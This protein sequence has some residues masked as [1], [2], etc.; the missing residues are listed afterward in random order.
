VQ[1]NAELL[2]A[3]PVHVATDDATASTAVEYVQPAGQ[4]F[5]SLS[6]PVEDSK[7]VA[8]PQVCVLPTPASSVVA[9]PQDDAISAE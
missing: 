6:A 9:E 4:F 1:S 5:S 2:V 3:V 8:E 7:K